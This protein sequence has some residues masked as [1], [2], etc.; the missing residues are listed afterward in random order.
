MQ[1]KGKGN[2]MDCP[3][4]VHVH[5]WGMSFQELTEGQFGQTEAKK[6]MMIIFQGNR[7]SMVNIFLKEINSQGP[8][9]EFYAFI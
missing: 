1:A 4:V 2:G 8:L 3:L 7:D 6:S 5:S 9:Q